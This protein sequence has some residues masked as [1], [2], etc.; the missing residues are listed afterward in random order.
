MMPVRWERLH[1]SWPPA[2]RACK[3]RLIGA[4]AGAA[5]QVVTQAGELDMQWRNLATGIGTRTHRAG[6]S[7]P[8]RAA[9]RLRRTGPQVAA[10]LAPQY[11]RP[12]DD[13]DGPPEP[14]IGPRPAARD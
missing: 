1:V 2:R 6:S 11:G 10:F 3:F 12:V 13:P 9:E 7:A 14:W 8:G 4:A 5:P